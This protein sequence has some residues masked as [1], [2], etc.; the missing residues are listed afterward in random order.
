MGIFGWCAIC[1]NDIDNLQNSVPIDSH[2]CIYL[3][4]DYMTSKRCFWNYRN[5]KKLKS[6]TEWEEKCLH[7]TSLSFF[8]NE[9]RSSIYKCI[10]I[11]EFKLR[12]WLDLYSSVAQSSSKM[13]MERCQFVNS[14]F[15]CDN[16]GKCTALIVN[17]SF[18]CIIF[19]VKKCIQVLVFTDISPMFN[20]LRSFIVR[21][22]RKCYC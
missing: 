6:M 19:F 8:L 5:H 10:F 9:Y 15:S 3:T 20:Q 11:D 22:E 1:E 14:F 16:H 4:I 2:S 12:F 13:M 17:F 18:F 7:V 21:M